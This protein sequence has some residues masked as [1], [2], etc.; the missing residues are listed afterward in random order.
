MIYFKYLRMVVKSM[1]QYRANL[2]L[3]TIGQLLSVAGYFAGIALLFARFGSL[4]GWSFGEV[5][6]CFGV[7]T[8]AWSLTE[9]FARGF[10]VFQSTVRRGE[11]DR[12]LLRPRGTILQILGGNFEFTRLAKLLWA[13]AVL[14]VGVT[15]SGVEWS[16]LR[17][18]TLA[19]MVLSGFLIFS[20][21]FI[22]GAS[23]CFWTVEGL[24]FI[25]IF[26][27]G[28]RELAAYPLTIYTRWIRRFFTFILPFGCFNYLPLLYVTGRSANGLYALTPLFALAFLLPCLLM[29]R[30]GVRH[31]QSTGN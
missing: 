3:L 29:W 25:N 18:L 15:Q 9:C 5:A 22:L 12:V 13:F 6:L 11:F 10:D 23:V 27:D 31:Y 1:L 28:G 24:E 17:G 7:V 19:L 16:A 26:T 14:G 20:G 21:V 4:D 30:S 2:V 8:A